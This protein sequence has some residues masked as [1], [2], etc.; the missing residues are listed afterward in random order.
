MLACLYASSICRFHALY[1][2][3]GYI[4]YAV[5]QVD[6]PAIPLVEYLLLIPGYL[7]VSY[8]LECGDVLEGRWRGKGG[9]PPLTAVE[10]SHDGVTSATCPRVLVSVTAVWLIR[11]TAGSSSMC[12]GRLMVMS[13]Y[14]EA[15]MR[16]MSR[17][18]VMW[19]HDAL[20]LT[21]IND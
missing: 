16:W 5:R 18:S 6:C 15:A 20:Q 1:N 4:K 7:G 10:P 19:S 2:M 21:A 3:V 13:R 12:S 11:E 8:G 9:S 17:D 14:L